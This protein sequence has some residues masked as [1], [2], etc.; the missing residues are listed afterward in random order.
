MAS[1]KGKDSPSFGSSDLDRRVRQQRDLSASV[2]AGVRF[3][4]SGPL[5]RSHNPM[6]G[7]KVRKLLNTLGSKNN[8]R[9]WA[10]RNAYTLTFLTIMFFITWII[11]FIMEVLVGN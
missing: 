1:H 2:P 10:A 8:M 9:E 3:S 6:G 7:Q 4:G 11:Y 5:W